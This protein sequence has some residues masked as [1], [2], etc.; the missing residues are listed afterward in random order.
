MSDALY[1]RQ[2]KGA[3]LNITAPT[4]VSVVS[5]DQSIGQARIVRVIVIT[6]GSTVESVNDSATI[7]GAA[8]TNQVAAIPNTVGPILIDAPLLKGLVVTPGTGQVLSVTYD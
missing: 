3:A 1:F 7:A 6:A 2:G 8:N 5:P 4:Q